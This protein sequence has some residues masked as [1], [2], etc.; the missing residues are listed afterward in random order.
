MH[1]IVMANAGAGPSETPRGDKRVVRAYET[2]ITAPAAKAQRTD[3]A[4]SGGG[5]GGSGSSISALLAQLKTTVA[6]LKAADPSSFNCTQ[7]EEVSSAGL[8]LFSFSRDLQE[9]QAARE[10]E[11]CQQVVDETPLP[12]DLLVHALAYLPT[13]DLAAAAQVSRH[14]SSAIPEVVKQRL[15]RI[16]SRFTL[17]R[18]ET[19][20]TDLLQRVEADVKLA[21]EGIQ[22]IKTTMSDTDFNKVVDQLRGTGRQVIMAVHED[23]W[24][25]TDAMQGTQR[26]S[27]LLQ[28]LNLN[29]LPQDELVKH[30]ETV[31]SSLS[32]HEDTSSCPI[33]AL[34]LMKQMPVVVIE[35]HLPE[36]MWWATNQPCVLNA[37]FALSTLALLPAETLRLA[38]VEAEL[39]ASPLATS[40]VHGH[41][42]SL[43]KLLLS[44]RSA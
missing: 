19:Y 32:N 15:E 33:V 27:Q 7:A 36:L 30:L 41:R 34:S 22:S 43:A 25:K 18:G 2:P 12:F 16:L 4:A 6:A 9:L 5:G 3:A 10:A 21:K 23:L 17:G 37:E 40:G 13:K 26:G 14:F 29:W 42:D 39:A 44:I 8:A 35:R 1:A 31:L 38:N 28:V 20:C 24:P 11:R